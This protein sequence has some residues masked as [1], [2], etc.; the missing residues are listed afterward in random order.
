[1]ISKSIIYQIVSVLALG[2]YFVPMLVVLLKKLWAAVPFRLFALYWLICALANLVE[3]CHLSHQVLDLYTVIY[4]LLDIPFVLT[5]FYFSTT[6]P[7]VKKFIKIVAP[8]LLASG[9]VNCMIRG[10]NTGSLEYVLGGEL[11]IVLGVIVWEI[12]LKLQ[13]IRLTGPVKGL[14]LIYAALFFE[15]G[16]F[17]VIY[18]FDYF[19]PGTSTTTDNFLVYYLSSTV[20]LPVAICGFLTKG[21]KTPPQVVADERQWAMG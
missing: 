21:I 9:F 19:L 20:A 17:V 5:I 2:L 18:I 1:M 7:V 13:Q 15:Y 6:S 12:I 16:T 14:L 8:A 11:L 4:N 10:F 3:Y